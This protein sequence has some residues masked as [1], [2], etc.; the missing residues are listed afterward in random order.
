MRNCLSY[1]LGAFA[2]WRIGGHDYDGGDLLHQLIRVDGWKNVT[3]SKE[4][5]QLEDGRK[6]W[7]T[8]PPEV[9]EK[10]K[11][12]AI[13]KRYHSHFGKIKQK[14]LKNLTELPK[15]APTNTYTMRIHEMQNKYHNLV[16]TTR[17]FMTMLVFRNWERV[18]SYRNSFLKRQL[19]KGT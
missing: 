15:L 8:S 11:D 10:L 2:N 5:C 7:L 17:K 1:I 3:T 6:L 18:K 16:A 14:L 4:Y 19:E 12:V 9:L 13:Y